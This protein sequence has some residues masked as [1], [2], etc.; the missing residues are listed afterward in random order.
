M[1]NCTVYT[2]AKKVMNRDE[3]KKALKSGGKEF[4][5]VSQV[6][7][8]LGQVKFWS[9]YEPALKAVGVEKREDCEYRYIT[10][11]FAD[12]LWHTDKK[13]NRTFGVLREV[14]VTEEIEVYRKDGS[15]VIVTDGTALT[16]KV[17]TGKK[18]IKWG[19]V[20]AWTPERLVLALA[21]SKAV[22]SEKS[23]K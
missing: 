10:G 12:E 4:N 5:S 15:Q 7:K 17:P 14:E 22:R 20:S 3:V 8:L 19:K 18:E 6:I 21:Q 23:A 16:V 2:E 9:L 1:N 11:L 13:G